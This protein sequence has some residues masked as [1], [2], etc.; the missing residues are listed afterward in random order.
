[1]N[2]NVFDCCCLVCY[3]MLDDG[4]CRSI[5]EPQCDLGAQASPSRTRS[6]DHGV[7]AQTLADDAGTAT[8]PPTAD[9]MMVTP[10]PAADSRMATPPPAAN[11]GARGFVGDVGA[12]LFWSS[13][14]IVDG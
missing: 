9:S 5:A 7:A 2:L 8:P 6:P 11:I 12:P 13:M 10:P 14:W 3:A 4:L 1:L